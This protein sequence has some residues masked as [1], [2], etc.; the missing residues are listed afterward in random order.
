[1]LIEEE[2]EA[3]GI[4]YKADNQQKL[5]NCQQDDLK[6]CNLIHTLN[7][8]SCL[9][10]EGIFSCSVNHSFDFT[11]GHC[12]TH[13]GNH[14][15]VHSN[16][17]GFSSKCCLVHLNRVTCS[18]SAICWN[19]CT[20][21]KHHQ[22]SRYQLCSVNLLPLAVTFHSGFWLEGGL[23]RG[24]SISCLTVLVKANQAVHHLKE[25]EDSH[26]RPVSDDCFDKNCG[27]DHYWHWTSKVMPQD[28]PF[29][30]SLLFKLVASEL[31]KPALGLL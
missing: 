12:G 2:N 3:N 5:G 19:I 8:G 13:L 25:E 21:S 1:M 31:L 6:V 7:H 20:S 22:V 11:T 17:K 28:N 16:R 29:R 18:Q 9:S 24:H 30:F 15:G 4:Q 14:V 26:I 23:Q 27:P 10:K